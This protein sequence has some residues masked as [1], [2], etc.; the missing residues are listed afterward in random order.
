MA[1]QLPDDFMPNLN[2]Q[3]A[4]MFGRDEDNMMWSLE[5]DKLMARV[6]SS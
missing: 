3:L 1:F 6:R 4:V 2:R 5:T